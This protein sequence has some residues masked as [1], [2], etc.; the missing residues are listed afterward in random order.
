MAYQHIFIAG[1]L[2]GLKYLRCWAIAFSEHNDLD[3]AKLFMLASIIRKLAQ[4][5]LETLFSKKKN[6]EKTEPTGCIHVK[7]YIT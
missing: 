2:S 3:R 4:E 6:F 5:Y 7:K 1:I